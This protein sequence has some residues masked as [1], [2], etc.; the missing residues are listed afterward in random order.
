MSPEQT[1]QMNR[2]VDYRS[3]F[4]ALGATFYEQGKRISKAIDN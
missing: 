1:G 4:Y 3:D 2:G